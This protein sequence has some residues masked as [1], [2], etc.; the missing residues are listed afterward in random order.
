MSEWVERT[1]ESIKSAERNS[2]AM[3]PFGS[4]IKK[5]NFV[6]SGIPIIKGSNLTGDFLVEEN[7]S[8]LTIEKADE[9]SSANAFRGDLIITH[10]GTLGQVGIIPSDSLFDRYIISQSQ[11]KVSLDRDRVNPFFVYYFFKTRIG[12]QRLL[13]NASQV[14]VPAIARASTSVKSIVI[15]LPK[16][17]NIQDD[18]VEILFTLD[19]KIALNKKMNTTLEAMA[20]AL[21]KSWFVDFDPVKAKLAAVRCGRDPEKAA[22]AA[23][24]CKLIVPPGKPKPDNFEEKLPSAEAIDAAIA[25]LETL[26][27]EQMQSLKEKAAHFPSDFVESE[28]GLIPKSWEIKRADEIVNISIG[29]TPPRKE[30][31]WFS[32]DPEN[33]RWVSIKDLGDLQT[34]SLKSSEYLTKEAV[35]RF[36]IKVIPEDS[37]LLSF[38]L[39]VGRVAIADSPTTTNE[40]IAH[41]IP[42][43]KNAPFATAFIYCYLKQFNYDALSSTSSIAK[44]VNSKI[45]KSIPF[46]APNPNSFFLRAF[47]VET[48]N[49]FKMIK[50]N[51]YESSNLSNLRD[52]LLPKLLSG[53]ISVASD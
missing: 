20:Q 46:I 36:N 19:R 52:V 49:I 8:Y 13:E 44:A 38:K 45:I 3:G 50:N 32:R 14:G 42:R 24:A 40:A 18:I 1:I 33:V 29:K 5:E 34:Y 25:S 11:L 7:Y 22:M 51:N 9:L 6:E 21:F 17:K 12:Q 30:V 23:I 10:R 39:T 31:K 15:S 16:Q 4:R 43:S 37:V 53:E 26:S 27:E 2:I 28:L 41:L 35:K 47:R 48:D